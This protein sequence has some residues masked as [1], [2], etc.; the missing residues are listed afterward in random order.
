M[1]DLQGHLM[2]GSG[3]AGC[4]IELISN[5]R[6]L[7]NIATTDPTCGTAWNI[8]DCDSCCCEHLDPGGR[9]EDSPWFD[10]LVPAS[11]EFMGLFGDL[12]LG[13][14]GVGSDGAAPPRY[15]TFAGAVVSST[16]RG[17]VFGEQWLREQLTP[18]GCSICGGRSATYSLFCGEAN[19]APP[20]PPPNPIPDPSVGFAGPCCYGEPEALGA[21]PD[22]WQLIDDGTRTVSRVSYVAGSLAPTTGEGEM[23]ACYGRRVTFSLLVESSEQYGA[24]IMAGSVGGTSAPWEC[25]ECAPVHFSAPLPE[26]VEPDCLVPPGAVRPRPYV[27]STV[28]T[29]APVLSEVDDL[30]APLQWSAPLSAWRAGMLTPVTPFGFA[31]LEIVIYA[32]ATAVTNV[33]VG[34]W[35]AKTGWPHIAHPAARSLYLPESGAIA[36]ITHIPAGGTLTLDGRG[37]RQTL[38]CNGRDVDAARIVS[39]QSGGLWRSPIVECGRR[40]WVA[41]DF[42]CL[43][44]PDNEWRMDVRLHPRSVA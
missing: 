30:R 21:A 13:P 41:I 24:P 31:D 40:Q 3:C 29:A 6:T 28:D 17:A 22:A 11:G 38:Y 32:G 14:A 19:P 37:S 8:G 36:R 39:R 1:A 23:P 2:L 12:T 15:I 27:I 25:C 35:A 26:M 44:P 18:T 20:C 5:C 16:E 33:S 10:R 34:I 42:D 7:N 4:E 9:L 43:T